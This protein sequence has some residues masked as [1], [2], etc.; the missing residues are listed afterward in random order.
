[1]ATSGSTDYSISRNNLIKQALRIIGATASGETPNADEV[2]E[3]NE[4]LNQMLKAWSA[5]G[6]HL[7][8]RTEVSNTLIVGKD[9]YLIGPSGD[10]DTTRPLKVQYAFRR[11]TSNK[12]TEL[13]RIS[14]DEYWRLPNK[15]RSNGTTTTYAFD[16]QLGNAVLYVWPPM[17]AASHTIFL[18][19]DMPIEDMDASTDDLELPQ[20]WY[21]ALKWSL[22]AELAAEYSQDLSFVSFLTQKAEME[23]QRVLDFDIETTS[24]FIQRSR[25]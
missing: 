5:D 20:E 9:K 11:D 22:A 10:I 16:P 24:I 1:M 23:R 3:A 14:M 12:D 15:T 8:K 4:V 7:W 21:Q 6:V 17:S 25:Y 18:Q 2:S 19:C 13:Y